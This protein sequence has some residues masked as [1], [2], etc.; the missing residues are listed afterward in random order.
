MRATVVGFSEVIADHLLEEAEMLL[1]S[2]E[3]VLTDA[4]RLQV[5]QKLCFSRCSGDK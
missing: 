3:D 1:K 2:T 5:H 4:V